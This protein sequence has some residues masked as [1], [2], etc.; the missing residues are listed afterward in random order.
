M[1]N[2]KTYA[3]RNTTGNTRLAAMGVLVINP[4]LFVL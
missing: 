3:D 2:R 4:N 1:T